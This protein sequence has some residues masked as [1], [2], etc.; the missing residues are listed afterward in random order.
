MTCQAH[1]DWSVSVTLFVQKWNPGWTDMHPKRALQKEPVSKEGRM[2]T[3][4]RASLESI[5]LWLQLVPLQSIIYSPQT[6][7]RWVAQPQ[8]T[9]TYDHWMMNFDLKKKRVS[10][11]FITITTPSWMTE[12][13]HEKCVLISGVRA[14][15]RTDHLPNTSH[16]RYHLRL[17][18]RCQCIKHNSACILMLRLQAAEI[19]TDLPFFLSN[20][21]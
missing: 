9:L 3:N 20:L 6:S 11:I 21:L 1:V 10:H 13:N 16:K 12:E 14:K 15:S 8:R 17:L 18:A 4:C 19:R 5:D 7:M 2:I